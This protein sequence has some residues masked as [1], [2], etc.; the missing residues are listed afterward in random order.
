MKERLDVLLTLRGLAESREAAQR[1]IRAG[2]V[3]SDTGILSKPGHRFEDTIPLHVQEPPRFVS[4]GGDKLDAALEAFAVSPSGRVCMDVGSSTGGFTDCLLQRGAI[5]V[6]CVD[7][8]KG[9]LHWRLRNDPRVVCMEG[10][11]ARYLRE[12]DIAERPGLACI[13]VS[14][15][16]LTK[17]LPAVIGVLGVAADIVVLIKPQFEAGRE[18]VGK[19]GVVRDA[20][21]RAA[22]VAKIRNFSSEQP[23]LLWEGE[24]ESPLR[25]PAGNVEYLAHLR[26]GDGGAGGGNRR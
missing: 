20:A 19:G 15:I 10:V 8:G 7:V 2:R 18:E 6:F 24:I 23:G 11:N 3:K 22:V 5:R 4:R 16:S 1:L 12:E 17:V 21:V 9:Q 26:L 14:F 13:D 25:G